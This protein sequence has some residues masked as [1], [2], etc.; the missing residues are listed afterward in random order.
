[1]DCSVIYPWER[2]RDDICVTHMFRGIHLGVV[3]NKRQAESQLL[4]FFSYGLV[5]G[6]YMGEAPGGDRVGP[7][8]TI[9]I[10]IPSL[11]GVDRILR[12]YRW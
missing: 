7:I 5:A 4:Q 11:S 2:N 9:G 6:L 12:G 1:M 3:G 10:Y 8:V